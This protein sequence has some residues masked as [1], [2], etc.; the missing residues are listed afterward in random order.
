MVCGELRW[1]LLTLRVIPPEA[2][3]FVYRA[4]SPSSSISHRSNC[5]TL[6]ACVYRLIRL[7]SRFSPTVVLRVEYRWIM[8]RLRHTERRLVSPNASNY[9][10]SIALYPS[11]VIH[12]VGAFI[13]TVTPLLGSLCLHPLSRF[14]YHCRDNSYR[15]MHHCSDPSRLIF[16]TR[17]SPSPE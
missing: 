3:L 10:S 11:V 9:T 2:I 13:V 1:F 6:F 7:V 4:F 15:I 5:L 16:P 12:S 8:C 14:M 17:A